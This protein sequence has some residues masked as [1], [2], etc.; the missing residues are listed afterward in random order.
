MLF[1]VLPN[2]S[3]YCVVTNKMACHCGG[4][5]SACKAKAKS[6]K[7]PA[8]RGTCKGGVCKAPRKTV[9]SRK[10]A[11]VRALEADRDK[12]IKN[13]EL[14]Y[15]RKVKWARD[16]ANAVIA[17]YKKDYAQKIR[18]ATMTKTVFTPLGY[19]SINRDSG[20][21]F[22]PPAFDRSTKFAN[23][24]YID[25]SKRMGPA[26]NRATKPGYKKP[27]PSLPPL[28]PP[29]PTFANKPKAE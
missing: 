11:A 23:A 12:L 10:S 29:P 15:N 18:E 26:V 28:F 25:R 6:K 17:A 3:V 1:R 27:L 5:C 7:K 14:N 20:S 8:T 21:S 2:F 4:S 24:P 19:D 22:A 16:E 9:T 13:A